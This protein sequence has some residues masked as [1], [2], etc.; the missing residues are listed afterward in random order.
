MVEK[1]IKEL[2]EWFGSSHQAIVKYIVANFD[3]D[4]KIANNKV[5]LALT[6][7]VE[8]KRL[9]QVKGAGASAT[10][11]LAKYFTYVSSSK[12][13]HVENTAAKTPTKKSAERKI[14]MEKIKE[15]AYQISPVKISEEEPKNANTP[16]VSPEE[17]L[18]TRNKRREQ[19]PRA[20]KSSATMRKVRERESLAMEST[21]VEKKPVESPFSTLFWCMNI[22][23]SV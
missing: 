10:F 2:R 23:K 9:I 15:S 13:S 19:K 12:K 17:N 20:A 8:S 22:L 6:R 11:K 3:V 21:A 5:K 1:A 4:K 18:N 16:S 7:G 14:P